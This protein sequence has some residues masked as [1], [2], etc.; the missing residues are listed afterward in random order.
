MPWLV[1]RVDGRLD[2][3]SER[4][5]DLARTPLLQEGEEA[6]DPDHR[7]PDGPVRPLA[8]AGEVAVDL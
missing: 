8:G 5:Q 1:E 4:P 2:G 6:V 7:L 3:R